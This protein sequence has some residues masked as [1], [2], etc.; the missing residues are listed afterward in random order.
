[1]HLLYG[2]E[3]EAL[4]AVHLEQKVGGI[5]VH[6]QSRQGAGRANPEQRLV[7]EGPH[8]VQL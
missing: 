1:M 4:G 6:V 8:C 2:V 3:P 7:V 5:H